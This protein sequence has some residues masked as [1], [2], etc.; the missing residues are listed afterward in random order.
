MDLIWWIMFFAWLLFGC[1][2]ATG[3]YREW[4]NYCSAATEFRNEY[5][6]VLERN[7]SLSASVHKAYEV[8]KD[9]KAF[10]IKELL[11]SKYL[12]YI[13][14][15]GN[16]LPPWEID[17][18]EFTLDPR[19]VDAINAALEKSKVRIEEAGLEAVRRI[20]NKTGAVDAEFKVIALPPPQE[21][22]KAVPA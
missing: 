17:E 22:E 3:W 13:A 12:A 4:L 9:Y 11:W 15:K 19:I 1:L 18:E 21:G 16:E 7:K 14:D 8:A 5:E 2:M 6:A 20:I 10:I